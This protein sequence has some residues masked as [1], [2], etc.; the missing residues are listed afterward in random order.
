M[1]IILSV[2]NPVSLNI[3]RALGKMTHKILQKRHCMNLNLRFLPANSTVRVHRVLKWDNSKAYIH[4]FIMSKV[5]L[6]TIFQNLCFNYLVTS[7]LVSRSPCFLVMKETHV[8]QC[9][10]MKVEHFEHTMEPVMCPH[11]I[12]FSSRKGE[13]PVKISCTISIWFLTVSL[14][15]RIVHK[16]QI[17]LYSV[18][19]N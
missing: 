17:L 12:K 14:K 5:T 16:I 18:K 7:C 6:Q 8:Q 19:Y 3:R 15:T 1:T 13:V 9:Q 11:E 10:K 2:V 4:H